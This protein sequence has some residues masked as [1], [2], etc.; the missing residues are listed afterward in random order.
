MFENPPKKCRA[1][2]ASQLIYFFSWTMKYTSPLLKKFISINDTPENIA[3][4][5]IL[6]TCEIEEVHHRT[7]AETIV[8]WYVKSCEQHPDADKLKV[9]I[10]DCGQK[11]EYQIICGGSN[12][13]AWLY[14]PVALPGT[15][16]E[17]AGIT[18][19]P[20]KMRGIISNGMICSKEEIWILEDLEKHSIWSLTEDL[21]DISDADLWTALSAKFPRLENRVMEVDNKSLT[22]RPDLTGHFGAA[23]ELNAIYGNTK[24]AI[25]FNKI[26]EYYGQCTP[27]HI[28]QILENSTKPER[29][30]AGESDGLNA[31][32]LLHLKNIEVQQASFFTRLQML[33]LWSNPISNWVDFSNL[34]MNISGQPIHFFDAE[35]VDGDI[36]VRNAKDGEKFTDLFET[37]HI[38]KA[39][40][41]VIADTKKIL[42]LAGVVWWL[43]SW[44]TESTKNILVEIANFDP[45]AVRKTWTRLSL[46][47]DAELRFEKNI[48]PRYTL[49][50]L[51]LFL[52][53]LNY[54]KKD[55]GTFDIG[56]LSY[57]I[58]DKLKAQSS[59]Q[60]EVDM[61]VM[62]QFIFGKKIKWFDKTTEEILTGLWFTGKFSAQNLTLTMPLWRGPDDLNIP[63]DIYE[64]VA[65]IYGYDQIENLPL[66]GDTTYVPYTD[67]VAIQRKLED[68]LVRTIGCN[69]TETYPRISEKTLKELG[70][71]KDHMYMLQNPVNP[72]APYM[73]DDMV[74]GLLAHTAKNSKFF[75]TCKIFDIGKIWKKD[76]VVKKD[77][78]F[79]S[80]FVNEQTELWVM[81]YEKSIDQWN[82][83]PILE[84]KKIVH[85]IAKELELEKITFE[86][87]DVSRFRLHPKKQALIKIGELVIWFVGALHPSI[88][89][90]NKIGEISGVVYLSLNITTIIE[91]S[92]KTSE[93]IYTYESLQDQIIRRDLCFVVESSNSFDAVITA[94][95][96]LSEVKEVEVFDVYAGKNLGEDK[97]SVSIKIKMVGDPVAAN[98]TGWTMTTEQINDIMNKAIKAAEGA[99]GTLRA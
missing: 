27:T 1:F 50:C 78:K 67:Y 87:P 55:L 82:K 65:R 92:K 29:K 5:L 53:E 79:A 85:V 48:N 30:V 22:N 4:N 32:L 94:V 88:L 84:A 40:D 63:E 38:L 9:C 56:W 61:K 64:E 68:V 33:D 42:A 26:K 86:K 2:M 28:M 90:N 18:I 91:H 16:F 93:H 49:F 24:W 75:D 17:K 99:G 89:Q 54:Y 41:V 81:L 43:E 71:N 47:T 62:E 96:N 31:Y 80:D 39:T 12:V 8:I 59:K 35:K 34:F 58:S 6:K 11:W 10:V 83:D 52:D 95:K 37:Q 97:K 72:E 20:R 25:T 19:E 51:I 70:R 66:L 76:G 46:R 44:I 77:S 7:I 98:G 69:Q 23:T 73:R 36:I 21:E 74:Y 57:V 3:K 60:I 15:V 13:A 14:V 45:V